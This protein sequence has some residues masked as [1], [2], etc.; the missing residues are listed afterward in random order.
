MLLLG[1][2]PTGG[3]ARGASEKKPIGIGAVVS[4][5]LICY[6]A[7]A[8]FLLAFSSQEMG[9]DDETG[10]IFVASWPARNQPKKIE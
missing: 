9:E 10:L 4:S 2:E 6:F 1:K 7:Q 8:C 3:R 5:L